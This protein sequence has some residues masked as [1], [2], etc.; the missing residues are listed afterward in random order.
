MADASLLSG[1][2]IHDFDQVLH[3]EKEQIHISGNR[4]GLEIAQEETFVYDLFEDMGVD[5]YPEVCIQT[6][7]LRELTII[8]LER[9]QSF[10]KKI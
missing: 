5:S 6:R 8:W 10:R 3:G 4:C 9:L 7:K 1:E 2:I